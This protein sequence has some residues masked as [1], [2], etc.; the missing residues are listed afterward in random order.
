MKTVAI[1]DYGA[2]NLFSLVKAL[3]FLGAS[4]TLVETPEAVEGS[5]A[6][7]IPGV[8][9]FPAG[10][11]ALQE[12]GLVSAIQASA[13]SGKHLLGICLGAQLL[14]SGGYE[15]GYTQGLGCV[16][17]RVIKFPNLAPGYRVPNINWNPV[18]LPEHANT[19]S[20]QGTPLAHTLPGSHFYFVHSF[21]C[22]PD[23]SQD[24]LAQTTYG[25]FSFCCVYRRGNMVGS[26]FH[27]EKSGEVGLQF[28]KT[29][30]DLL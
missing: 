30:L 1:V 7:I 11:K 28:L 14:M 25:G 23:N 8:G 26:Q 22:E 2:G 10:M 15:F 17:G 20:W 19:D 9:A 24:V 16:P 12:R 6:L 27:P 18:E 29:F 13:Q 5:D 21:V 4:P 3:R